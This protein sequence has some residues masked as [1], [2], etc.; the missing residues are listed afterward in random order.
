MSTIQNPDMSGFRIPTV[1]VLA[2][3]FVYFDHLTKFAFN[4]FC[5]LHWDLTPNHLKSGLFA[6]RISAIAIVATIQKLNHSK[7][8]HFC[9]DFKW[10]LTKWRPFVQIF[11]RWASR[12]QIPFATQPLIDNSESNQVWIM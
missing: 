11:N 1:F 8:R 12:F 10:F 7:P 3:D 5:V 6:G 2:L 9:L 4:Q